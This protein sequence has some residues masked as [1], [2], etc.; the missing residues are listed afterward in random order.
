M[1]QGV[2]I[3]NMRY[4]ENFESGSGGYN[5]LDFDMADGNILISSYSS[6]DESQHD[7]VIKVNDWK[8]IRDAIDNYFKEQLQDEFAKSV[9]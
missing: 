9:F 3:D 2:Y 5:T 1:K 6:K 8:V 7:F 4:V